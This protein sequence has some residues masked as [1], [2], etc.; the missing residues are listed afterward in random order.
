MFDNGCFAIITADAGAKNQMILYNQRGNKEFVWHS[1]VDNIMDVSLS[2]NGKRIAIIS[3]ELIPGSINTKILMFNRG[4]STA[5]AEKKYDNVLFTNIMFIKNNELFGVSDAGLYYLDASAE[6]KKTYPFNDKFLSFFKVAKDG[7]TV[8]NFTSISDS[9]SYTEVVKNGKLKGSYISDKPVKSIDFRNDNI[10]LR[11]D[12]S[13]EIL[14]KR[15]NRLRK[16]DCGRELTDA[17]FIG[18][19]KILIVEKTD[20]KIIK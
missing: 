8:L 18:S 10:L 3:A 13:A 2:P 20:V 9:T 5:Y 14:S 15:A 4:E 12:N 16:I 17:Y 7:T 19:G 6:T 11:Y 1:G